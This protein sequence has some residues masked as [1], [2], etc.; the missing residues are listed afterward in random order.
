MVTSNILLDVS[1]NGTQATLYMNQNEVESRRIVVTL[2]NDGKKIMLDGSCHAMIYATIDESTISNEAE[3]QDNKILFTFKSAYVKKSGTLNVQIRVEQTK[4]NNPIVL[5][6][7][8]LRIVV[9]KTLFDENSITGTTEFVEFTRSINE[10]KSSQIDS[11]VETTDGKKHTYTVTFKAGNTQSFIVYDGK[12]GKNGKDGVDAVEGIHKIIVNG[13]E[14]PINDDKS[15]SLSAQPLIEEIG[16]IYNQSDV[17]N[18]ETNKVYIAKISVKVDNY[19][20]S[21]GSLIFKSSTGAR[22]VICADYGMIWN[23]DMS[24]LWGEI[25]DLITLIKTQSGY[26]FN[27]ND[28]KTK[29]NFPKTSEL[30]NDS[31][32]V[33]DAKYT[34]TDE[35]FTADEKK[36]LGALVNYDDTAIKEQIAKKQDKLSKEQL[37]NISVVPNKIDKSQVGNG[38]K[39]ADGMLQ[40]DIPVATTSTTYGGDAQ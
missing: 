35:N 2:N 23:G 9:S 17:D 40:L 13:S 34:H 29:I 32:F 18:M 12:D 37:E 3:I 8:Q 15:V 20:C 10:M 21:A 27:V 14:L 7:P 6:S 22:A 19:E 26:E 4:D 5:Y 25:K 38:L 39:F 31:N 33:S 28:K 11:I 30:E 1:K 36:K 16:F 24:P